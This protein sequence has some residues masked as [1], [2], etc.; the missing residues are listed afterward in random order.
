MNIS[1]FGG[2]VSGRGIGSVDRGSAKLGAAIGI[3]NGNGR[4][5]MFCAFQNGQAGKF[6]S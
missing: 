5:P 1:K 4:G 3:G 2:I 6:A